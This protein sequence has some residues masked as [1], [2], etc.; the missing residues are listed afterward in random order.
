MSHKNTLYFEFDNT[1]P[2]EKQVE[3]LNSHGYKTMF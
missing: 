2:E 3:W 1:V